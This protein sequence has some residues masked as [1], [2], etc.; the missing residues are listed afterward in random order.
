MKMP[1]SIAVMGPCAFGFNGWSSTTLVRWDRSPAEESARLIEVGKSNQQ[2]WLVG[3]DPG[4]Q[5][6]SN[7]FRHANKWAQSNKSNRQHQLDVSTAGIGCAGLFT[8]NSTLY[9]DGQ[10]AV[11]N[12]WEYIVSW[13]AGSCG[14]FGVSD[15]MEIVSPR[16]NLMNWKH[17]IMSSHLRI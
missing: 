15:Q 1:I 4:Y 11:T 6:N 7:H 8:F 3:V 14:G 2:Q 16:V 10:A 12:D 13:I 9:L 17:S 5:W